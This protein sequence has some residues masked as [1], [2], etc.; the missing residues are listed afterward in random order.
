MV[1][2]RRLK[3]VIF[4]PPAES[5]YKSGETRT[6]PQ[7]ELTVPLVVELGPEAVCQTQIA[8]SRPT[9]H[10]FHNFIF[11]CVNDFGINVFCNVR[12]V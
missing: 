12:Y 4:Q 11:Y 1:G 5:I 6:K 9:D 10:F 8:S 7:Q 3:F 2:S